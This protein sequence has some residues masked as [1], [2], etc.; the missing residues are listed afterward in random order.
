MARKF[1]LTIGILALL[2]ALAVLVLYLTTPSNPSL[3]KITSYFDRNI[4][5]LEINQ[6]AS[7]KKKKPHGMVV[8]AQSE[9]GKKYLTEKQGTGRWK[10]TVYFDLTQHAIDAGAFKKGGTF[11]LPLGATETELISQK[12]IKH[13]GGKWEWKGTLDVNTTEVNDFYRQ[14]EKVFTGTHAHWKLSLER[15]IKTRYTFSLYCNDDDREWKSL[16]EYHS[17]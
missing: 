14:A 16:S 17:F 15:A 1:L 2:A 4:G 11:Y 12:I 3:E 5:Y 9:V 6:S 8:L 13:D 10:N 7:H